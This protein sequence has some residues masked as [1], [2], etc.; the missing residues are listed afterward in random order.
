MNK[1]SAKKS[2][3]IKINRKNANDLLNF[4]GKIFTKENIIDRQKRVLYENTYVFFPLSDKLGKKNEV[5]NKI[6]N[7]FKFEIIEK[8]E[9]KKSKYKYKTIEDALRNTLPEEIINLAP[10]SYDIVGKIAIIEF[11]HI[12]QL[13]FVESD[14]IKREIA[15]AVIEVNKS[16]NSVYEKK[17][18]IKGNFR[19][20]ELNLLFGEDSS[21]TLYKENNCSFK[22]D[23]KKTYFTPRLVYERR[24]ISSLDIKK[25]EL[26][27]DLFAGVGPISVQIAK[28]HDVRIYSF[29]MNP[30][31]YKYLVENIKIN[32]LRGKIYPFNIN[33]RKL[34]EP[35]NKLGIELKS[36]VDRII[37]NLP[38]KSNKYI[39]IACFLLKQ[40]TGVLHFYKFCEKP[41]SI[42]NALI[43]LEVKLK[44][45]HL[46]INKILGSRIV[47]AFSPKL[48]LVVVDLTIK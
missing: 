2:D 20:R 48:D 39:D 12:N 6:A 3:Y 5:L 9:K 26:I 1:T 27:I 36:K 44:E 15:K 28:N 31:A 19:L 30:Y 42:K 7:N 43:N 23:I 34:I 38:E 17:S 45:I 14:K 21:E 33:V 4:L 46:S 40:N 16:V 35:S 8:E 10:K 29:D 18:E 37:M 25:G 32:K 11:D 13:N 47:K 24:R 22:L 41:N